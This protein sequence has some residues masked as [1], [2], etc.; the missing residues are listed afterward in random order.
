VSD[1]EI[2]PKAD[3]LTDG[4]WRR[5]EIESPCVKVCV[6]HPATGLCVGCYRTAGEIAAWSSLPPEARRATLA[7]LPSRA[8]RAKPKRRGGHAGRVE[9]RS[10]Q[11]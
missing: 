2:G 1:P 7:E 4:L 8:E 3:D 6:I 9:R 10:G 5:D 11:S